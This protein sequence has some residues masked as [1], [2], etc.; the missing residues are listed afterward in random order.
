MFRNE[1]EPKEANTVSENRVLAMKTRRKRSFPKERR[2]EETEKEE[3]RNRAGAGETERRQRGEDGRRSAVRVPRRGCAG[4]GNT[5]AAP[6]Q[7]R[8][9]R[10]G[11]GRGGQGRTP[12]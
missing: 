1:I 9:G 11:Q 3:N 2:L 4:L 5:R 10:G 7:G 6:H 8:E 12:G